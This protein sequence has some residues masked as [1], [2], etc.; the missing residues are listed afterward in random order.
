M[1]VRFIQN[2]HLP[3]PRTKRACIFLLCLCWGF[4]LAI[5]LRNLC[6]E[7][8]GC[9]VFPGMWVGHSNHTVDGRNP[10]PVDME[11]IHEYP[12]IYT[13]SKKCG[14]SESLSTANMTPSTLLT[15]L[16]LRGWCIAVVRWLAGVIR[17]ASSPKLHAANILLWV[18]GASI[19]KAAWWTKTH[20]I[21]RKESK[22]GNMCWLA[23]WVFP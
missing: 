19:R 13:P 10:A 22:E 3:T 7:S 21:E 17:Q 6:L 4:K 9:Y 12:T 1:G 14:I 23:I 15:S 5:C 20:R 8:H 11:N 16:S 2:S 18:L